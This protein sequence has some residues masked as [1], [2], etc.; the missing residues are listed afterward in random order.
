MNLGV[1]SIMANCFCGKN[2]PYTACCE[3]FLNEQKTP[4]TPEEL[5]R[6]RYTAYCLLNLDY[7]QKTMK[8]PAADNFDAAEIKAWARKIKW[9]GLQVVKSEY[10]SSCGIVEFIAHYTFD[11]KKNSLHEVSEFHFDNG[12]WYYVNGSYPDSKKA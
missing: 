9:S 1:T 2:K 5:M 7:I 12:K 4:S 3:P 10:N 8:S 6:S 11:G